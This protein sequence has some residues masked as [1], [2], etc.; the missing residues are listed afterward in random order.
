MNW[1][2]VRMNTAS[3]I[4]PDV[5]TRCQINSLV[6]H[7]DPIV[8]VLQRKEDRQK[9]DY[10]YIIKKKFE[11][12]MGGAVKTHPVFP[13]T[14]VLFEPAYHVAPPVAVLSWIET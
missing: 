5:S 14:F 2:H 6:S 11:L 8:N 4:Q 13:L 7:D 1:C 10:D 9:I 3:G 12:V